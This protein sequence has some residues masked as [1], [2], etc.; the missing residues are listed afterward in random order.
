MLR[1]TIRYIV[2]VKMVKKQDFKNIYLIKNCYILQKMLFLQKN[3]RS[4]VMRQFILKI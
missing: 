1:D 4:L 2:K 3:I